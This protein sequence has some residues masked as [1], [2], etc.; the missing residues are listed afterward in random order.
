MSNRPAPRNR[1]LRPIGGFLRPRILQSE[2]RR[3]HEGQREKS[4]TPLMKP[5]HWLKGEKSAAPLTKP[6]YWLNGEEETD[7]EVAPTL[8]NIHDLLLECQQQV[9]KDADEEISKTIQPLI[10]I[11]KETNNNHIS[12]F[13]TNCNSTLECEISDNESEVEK[14]TTTIWHPT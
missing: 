10:N 12:N 6:D 2:F 1:N 4:A 14:T 11:N 13:G 9:N 5:E 7:T 3:E 8:P